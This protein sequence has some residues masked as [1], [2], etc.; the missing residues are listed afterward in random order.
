MRK[1]NEEIKRKLYVPIMMDPEHS[2]DLY[3]EDFKKLGVD[4]VFLCDVARFVHGYGE[5]YAFALENAKKTIKLYEERGYEC[6]VWINTLGYGVADIYK[7]VDT[8]Q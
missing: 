4:H 6:G 7:A 8:N 5:R 3:D 1:L 2:A